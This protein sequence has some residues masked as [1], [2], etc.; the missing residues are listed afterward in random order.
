MSF[1]SNVSFYC[2]KDLWLLELSGTHLAVKARNP[3][4][5]LQFP[6]LPR[7]QQH[8]SFPF[9]KQI[10]SCA[11]LPSIALPFIPS[12]CCLT[13]GYIWIPPRR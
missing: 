10:K 4:V 9:T 11:S 5:D 12:L 3:G 8:V 7:P 13:A 1:L 2:P 6:P